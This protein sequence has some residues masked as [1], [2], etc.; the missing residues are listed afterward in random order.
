MSNK[1]KKYWDE[2]RSCAQ[3]A[4]SMAKLHDT[5]VVDEVHQIVDGHSFVIYYHKS[6]MVVAQSDNRNSYEDS[7]LDYSKGFDALCSQVAYHAMCADIQDEV[8]RIKEGE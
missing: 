4:V 6:L 5:E 1:S 2:V 8:T 3:C 7:A